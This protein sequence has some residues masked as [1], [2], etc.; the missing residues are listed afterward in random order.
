MINMTHSL[1]KEYMKSQILN[2]ILL[3][4]VNC[5]VDMQDYAIWPAPKQ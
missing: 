3:L 4:G 1:S 5:Y 2:K